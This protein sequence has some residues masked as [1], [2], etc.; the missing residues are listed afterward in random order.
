MNENVIPIRKTDR[1]GLYKGRVENDEIV[2]TDQL[3][4]AYIKPG[5]KMFRLRFWM[6]PKENYFLSEDE[7]DPTKYTI[8]SLDEYQLSSG[9]S[10][11]SWNVIGKGSLSGSFIRLNFYLLSEEVFLSLYPLKTKMEVPDVA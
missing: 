6:F 9:E 2:E 8:L 5:S 7:N 4:F 3:G 1:Y 11:R 10:R